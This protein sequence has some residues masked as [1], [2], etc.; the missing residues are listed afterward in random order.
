MKVYV[1]SDSSWLWTGSSDSAL[2]FPS[3]FHFLLIN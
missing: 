1:E 2:Q 3:A